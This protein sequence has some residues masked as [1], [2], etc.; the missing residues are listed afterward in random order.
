ML[1]VFPWARLLVGA[2]HCSVSESLHLNP[3]VFVSLSL[4]FSFLAFL[5]VSP[6]SIYL[7]LCFLLSFWL[8]ICPHLSLY[9]CISLILCHCV[10]S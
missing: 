4:L 5:S 10:S 9:L 1:V 7:C 2:L 6:A 8:S 3:H